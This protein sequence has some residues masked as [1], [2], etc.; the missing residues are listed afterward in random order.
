MA[1]SYPNPRP[2]PA[3]KPRAL[4]AHKQRALDKLVGHLDVPRRPLTDYEYS[5]E[6]ASDGALYSIRLQRFLK[7]VYNH[8]KNSA[9]LEFEVNG[10][11]IRMSPGKA[12]AL[13]FFSPAQRERVADEAYDIQAFETFQDVKGHPGIEQL[14]YKYDLSE[15]AIFY[16][17]LAAVARALPPKTTPQ[18]DARKGAGAPSIGA[19]PVRRQNRGYRPEETPAEHAIPVQPGRRTGR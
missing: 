2:S 9:E 4:D 19:A 18:A 1:M 3:S 13:S 12:V 8:E 14:A 10:E 11:I 16:I 5:Y 17:L 6:I 7:P 15:G